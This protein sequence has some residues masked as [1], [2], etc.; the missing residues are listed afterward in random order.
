MPFLL[1]LVYYRWYQNELHESI[2]KNKK[3]SKNELVRLVEW[4]VGQRGKF[5][6]RLLDFAKAAT[7][8]AVSDASL[9]SFKAL[10]K[11]KETSD[12]PTEALKQALAP[13]SELKGIGPATTTAALS[14]AHPS[15]PFLSDEAMLAALGSRDYT[16]KAAVQLTAALQ[17]KAREL[18]SNGD[19]RWTAKEIEQCLFA[20]TKDGAGSKAGEKKKA[21]KKRK[22]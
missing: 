4:K 5:R 2:K 3:L 16:V 12:V 15:I 21:T 8:G 13:L 7:E 11:F 6:P 14:A 9:R 19:K 17:K 20:A 1:S 10:E 18:S 22:R